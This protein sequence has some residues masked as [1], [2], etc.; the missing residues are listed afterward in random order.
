MQAT[1]LFV[2]KTDIRQHKHTDNQ[3]V[4]VHRNKDYYCYYFTLSTEGSSRSSETAMITLQV[5]SWLILMNLS[6]A[7]DGDDIMSINLY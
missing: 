3:T 5:Q 1:R 7:Y 2:T 4:R 6:L